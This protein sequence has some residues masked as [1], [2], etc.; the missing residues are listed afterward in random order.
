[1][2]RAMNLY[3]VRAIY[4]FEMARTRRKLMQRII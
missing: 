4:N 3:A 1:M 2:S